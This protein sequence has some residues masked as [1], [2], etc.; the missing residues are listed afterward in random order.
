L[1]NA[2]SVQVRDAY[3]NPVPG[4]SVA[5]SSNHG[6]VLTPGS[7]TTNASGLASASFQLPTVAVKTTITA[8]SAGLKNATLVEFS[9]AGPAASVAVDDGNGQS[10]PAGSALPQPLTVL[11]TDQYGNPVS[12]ASV[13]F[14]DGGAGG[15]FLGANPGTTGNNGEFGQT[16]MLP[17]VEGTVTI[18][19]T[20]AGV[21]TPAVFTVVAD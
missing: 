12:G 2:L 11:V 16:Y 19:A 10:A 20:V 3:N 5:F 7:T 17:P 1:P 8:S 9:V 18:S 15:T 4:I 21:S 14:D 6:G 13:M